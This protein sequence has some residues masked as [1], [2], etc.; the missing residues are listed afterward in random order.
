MFGIGKLGEQTVFIRKFRWLFEADFPS[1]KIDPLFVKVSCRPIIP[2]KEDDNNKSFMT[3]IY[4]IQDDKL[5]GFY[6]ICQYFMQFG[7]DLFDAEGFPTPSV[8]EMLGKAK[9]GMYDGLGNLV[10]EW[11]FS[12]VWP[13]SMNFGDLDY[14]SSDETT[15]EVLWKYQSVQ[16]LN[17]VAASPSSPS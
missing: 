3:T 14:S 6:K 10:E 16:Y 15:I 9:L 12:G 17:P 1:G 2:G 11:M 7:S 4:D 13:K 5:Q 8:Q